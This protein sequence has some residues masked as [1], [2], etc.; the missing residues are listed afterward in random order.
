[1]NDSR[2]GGNERAGDVNGWGS[3]W[4]Y[5]WRNLVGGLENEREEMRKRSRLR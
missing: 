3:E 5:E 1:M 4:G 2:F